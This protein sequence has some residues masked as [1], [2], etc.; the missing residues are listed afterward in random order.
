MLITPAVDLATVTESAVV[1]VPLDASSLP[2]SRSCRSMGASRPLPVPR[3]DARVDRTRPPG[4]RLRRGGHDPCAD[5]S[6]R[7]GGLAR[8][9]GPRPRQR[10]PA[11]L[12]C[13]SPTRGPTLPTGEAATL[14]GNGVST[15]GA[16]PGVAVARMWLLSAARDACLAAEAA[17]HVTQLTAEEIAS[18]RAVENELAAAAV[19]VPA[20]ARRERVNSRRSISG[21]GVR[22]ERSRDRLHQEDMIMQTS[23]VRGHQRPSD[24]GWSARSGQDVGV[25]PEEVVRVVL[26]L[27]LAELRRTSQRRKASTT[28]SMLV[29]VQHVDV[30]A[31]AGPWGAT[32]RQLAGASDV[33]RVVGSASS[34]LIAK[35][36]HIW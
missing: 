15:L 5:H 6:A 28:R 17:G 24:R 9:I 31:P 21:R 36:S 14:R 29:E 4:Q 11:A 19:A 8:R 12:A 27:D 26:R 22:H 34:Q 32:A 10:P 16:T 18:W 7:A 33:V 23:T 2:P 20:T 13:I 3:P 25:D 35:L 1:E 30:D